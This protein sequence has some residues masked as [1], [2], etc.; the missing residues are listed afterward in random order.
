MSRVAF[1]SHFLD[2]A[3]QTHKRV[4]HYLLPSKSHSLEGWSQDMGLILPEFML[5]DH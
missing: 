3:V 4:G 5:S 2:E 1:S